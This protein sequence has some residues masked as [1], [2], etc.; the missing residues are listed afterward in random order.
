MTS[1]KLLWLLA[2]ICALTEALLFGLSQY[3]QLALGTWVDWFRLSN[4]ALLF[5][6]VVLALTQHKGQLALIGLALIG[7]LNL[8]LALQQSHT[9]QQ[10]QHFQAQAGVEEGACALNFEAPV[11]PSWL[12]YS[13]E[14]SSLVKVYG[15][16]LSQ[17]LI[18]L[19]GLGLLI[20]VFANI[21]QIQVRFSKPGL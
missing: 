18:S 4:L 5:A 13:G 6:T 2:S 21:R 11:Y 15:I 17:L 9:N 20:L 16:E 8:S 12:E 7:A 19:A 10:I 14:C 1:T 3:Y